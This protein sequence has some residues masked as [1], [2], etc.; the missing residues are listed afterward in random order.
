MSWLDKLG[1]KAFDAIDTAARR[2]E[3]VRL[4]V[5]PLLERTSL[6]ERLREHARQREIDDVPTPEQ[7]ASPFVPQPVGDAERPP[8]GKPDVA[9]QVFGRGTD[10][11]TART[12][13][14]LRD[15]AIDHEYID[16]EGEGGVQLEAQL[17][18]ET[19][20]TTGPWVYLRGEY[21]GGFNAMHELDRLGQLEELVV[22]PSQRGARAGR[23]RIVVEKRGGDELAPGERG[24]PD[25]RT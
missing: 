2:A 17:V 6:G 21:R 9:A 20:H 18:T 3:D 5:E 13:Q 24:N 1:K 11:W 8:L 7:N 19:K 10:P 22:P 15:R 12:R 4:R 14:L 16:L 23:I 25:D